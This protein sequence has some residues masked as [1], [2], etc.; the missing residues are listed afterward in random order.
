[1]TVLTILVS[2]VLLLGAPGAHRAGPPPGPGVPGLS[3]EVAALPASSRDLDAATAALQRATAT[4]DRDVADLASTRDGLAAA[5]AEEAATAA[6]IDRRHRQLAKIDAELVGRRAA[7]RQLATEWYVD[8]TADQ[9]SMDPTLGA[10]E[11][12]QL[13]RQAVLGSSAADGT[14]RGIRFM[15]ARAVTLSGDASSLE[16][17]RDRL[18]G[19]IEELAAR[20]STLDAAVAADDRAVD[21]AKTAATNARYNATVDGTD[22]SAVALDA[23][24]RAAAAMSLLDQGCG[25]TWWVLAG[26]GRTESGHGTEGGSSV[27]VDGSVTPPVLGPPLDGTT[28]W[29][30]VHDT[31]GGALD[32]DPLFDR[33]VGPMQFLPGTWKAFARDGNGD[34][35]ADPNNIYDAAMGAAA[36][37]CRSGAVSDDAGLRRAYFSYNHSQ[38]YVDTVVSEALAY[39]DAVALPPL[40]GR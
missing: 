20:A 4:R 25:M 15:S 16:H 23:Y 40:Q 31:D 26:I 18:G 37:L 35:R 5:T 3:P 30:V 21:A 39:R 32:G 2:G 11:L 14:T 22:M 19:R 1:M 13:R 28:R 29:A 10:R 36:Y 27:G 24:W 17:V 6:T 9:R 33:A 7:V 38:T 8:G 12:E 34:G